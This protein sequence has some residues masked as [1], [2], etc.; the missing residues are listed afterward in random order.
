M[1]L[2]GNCWT[3]ANP[4]HCLWVLPWCWFNSR[5]LVNGI[6]ARGHTQYTAHLPFWSCQ[7]SLVPYTISQ[8]SDKKFPSFKKQLVLRSVQDPE[9][10]ELC[11]AIASS[12]GIL[13]N[14][15][16]SCQTCMSFWEPLTCFVFNPLIA[17]PWEELRLSYV[18]E[19]TQNL[20]FIPGSFLVKV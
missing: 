14:L 15:T 10:R 1:N 9:H 12:N 8:V 7:L 20:S 19:H 13:G 6:V 17:C 18:L 11:I 5:P 2:L 4:S 3:E 16:V